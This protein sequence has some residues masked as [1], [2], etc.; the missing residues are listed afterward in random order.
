VRPFVL[1]AAGLV[2]LGG[3]PPLPAIPWPTVPSIT[4]PAPGPA[5]A[6][7]YVYEKDHTA[8]PVGVTVGL[9][10]LNRERQIVAT[11]LEA[12]TTNGAGTIPEQFRQAV[13]AA[14]ADGL[15]ALVVLSGSTVLAIV[16]APADAEQIVRAVP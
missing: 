11:L 2:L 14:K 1:L 13:A 3:L 10:R 5:T 4:A 15:P 8:V 12:D 6:A 16:K 9:N 7:V